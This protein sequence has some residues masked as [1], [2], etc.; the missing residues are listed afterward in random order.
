L[1]NQAAQIEKSVHQN[2]PS[3]TS[4]HIREMRNEWVRFNEFIVSSQ[5][6]N[7]SAP[8]GRS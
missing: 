8:C 3:E 7:P 1:Q 6:P 5:S 2:H 4:K